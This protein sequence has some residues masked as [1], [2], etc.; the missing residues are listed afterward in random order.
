M[1]TANPEGDAAA[2]DLRDAGIEVAR[3]MDARAGQ[4]VRRAVGGRAGLR[5]V[6]LGDGTRVDADLLVVSTGWTAPTA[7]LSMAGDRPVWDAAA[8]RFVPAGG[9]QDG[10]LAA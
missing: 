2:D 1:L 8:A 5:A 3:V 6:Q 10:V 7:L 4:T 9:L